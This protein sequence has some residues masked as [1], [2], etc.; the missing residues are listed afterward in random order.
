M[1]A[2]KFRVQFSSVNKI[3]ITMVLKNID[4]NNLHIQSYFAL[5]I[6]SSIWIAIF[7][8]AHASVTPTIGCV[9]FVIDV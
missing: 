4:F 7:T 5:L 2:S 6:I 3:S 1:V 9:P 8:A